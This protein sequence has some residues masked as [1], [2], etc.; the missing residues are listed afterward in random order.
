MTTTTTPQSTAPV[1]TVTI[2][3]SEAAQR[4]ALLAGQPS[5]SPQV[6]PVTSQ[7]DLV[8]LLALPGTTIRAD[9]SAHHDGRLYGRDRFRL[10]HSASVRLRPA[11]AAAAIAAIAEAHTTRFA[12]EDALNAQ[13]EASE[14]A[15]NAARDAERAALRAALAT[16]TLEGLAAGMRAHLPDDELRTAAERV[17]AGQTPQPGHAGSTAAYVCLGSDGVPWLARGVGTL[18]VPS[19]DAAI[20]TAQEA[21][22][23]AKAAED[24]AREAKR[25][26]DLASLD[27]ALKLVL[28]AEERAAV[29]AAEHADVPCGVL[30]V[31][32]AKA[33]VLDAILSPLPVRVTLEA[34]RTEDDEG[35]QGSFEVRKGADA[36]LNL[37]EA[38]RALE[39]RTA[40]T[41][42]LNAAPEGLVA[43]C[44]AV[45]REHAFIAEDEDDLDGPAPRNIGLR[46]R[47]VLAGGA[48]LVRE[49][50]V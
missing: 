40:V 42:S 39:V 41:R 17:F 1:S 9:G 34:P 15:R 45:L 36:V 3:L 18:R 29:Y 35:V 12:E 20:K 8:A 47:I 16:G 50:A 38:Q 11:D 46:V 19:F 49:L 13:A 5:H 21:E 7:E 28:S 6:Y 24:A 14:E 22:A 2:H 26:A 43:E 37:A 44:S 10:V 4:A 33:C 25:Q 23:A 31:D 48:V 27:A 32:D 30:S